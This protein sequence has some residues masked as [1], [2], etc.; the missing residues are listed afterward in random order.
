MKSSNSKT[1]FS[2]LDENIKIPKEIYLEHQYGLM[3]FEGREF[4]VFYLEK[5]KDDYFKKYKYVLEKE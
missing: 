5:P 3:E 2:T 1:V 4:L